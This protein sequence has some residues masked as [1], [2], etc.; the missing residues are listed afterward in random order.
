MLLLQEKVLQ[1][2]NLALNQSPKL[3]NEDVVYFCPNPTCHHK[4]KKFEVNIFSGKY[5]CWVC[6]FRGGSFRSLFNKIHAPKKCYDLIE[7]I[8]DIPVY[9]NFLIE[10]DKEPEIL[11][12]P[13][14]FIP[15]TEVSNDY[16]Y[17]KAIGYVKNRGIT[18]YDIMRYNIGYCPTG[19]Y[20]NRIILPSYDSK[21]NLNFFCGRDF[22][23][24][25]YKYK[26]CTFSKNIIG[27]DFFINFNEEITLVEGQLDAIAVRRNC[28]PL[29]GKTMSKKL[30]DTILSSR[31]PKVNVIL[32]DDALTS[33]IK[34]CEYLMNN[35]VPV[36]F[37]RLNDKDPSKMGF[38]KTW[39]CIR[40][41]PQL[42]FEKLVELKLYK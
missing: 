4:K 21:G 30:K 20:F 12:L 18:K 23:E 2:L 26:N 39:E 41:A 40:N 11:T 25:S 13:P 22:T 6:G 27:F 38:I 19:E 14:E 33:S 17:K 34:I 16:Y 5:N 31:V 36:H 28:I 9:T 24:K 10:Q 29:F 15:L 8:K 7:E 37:V 35:G 3:R 42:N 32:D 1:A